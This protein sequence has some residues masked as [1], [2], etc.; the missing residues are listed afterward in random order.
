MNGEH[1]GR[2]DAYAAAAAARVRVIERQIDE[3]G[4]CGYW[5]AP[6]R[7]IVVDRRLTEAE[8]RSTIWHE[9]Q[10]ARRGDAGECAAWIERCV[11]AAAARDALPLEVLIHIARAHPAPHD[12]AEALDVDVEMLAARWSDM[13]PDERRRLIDE[14]STHEGA[15]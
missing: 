7:T 1:G 12:A 11:E 3:Q 13:T 5:H 9:L 2:P 14:T 10:H 4:V 15:A 6:S 8:K